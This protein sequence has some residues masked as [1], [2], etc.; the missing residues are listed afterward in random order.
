MN[1]KIIDS[2]LN[3]SIT[4]L[5]IIG[6][7]KNTG[8]TVTLNTVI[9][10]AM[11][12]D[13]RLALLSYGRDGEEVDAITRHKKPRVYIP[14]RTLFLTTSEAANKSEITTK[15][16]KELEY[17]TTMGRVGIYESGDYGG[18]CEL[19]GINS[20][21][22]IYQVKKQLENQIDLLLIDGALDR[23]SSAMPS[24]SEGFVLATGANIANT[25]ELVAKKTIIEIDKL[26]TPEIN[27]E[28]LQVKASQLLENGHTGVITKTGEVVK[29]AEGCS[30][31]EYDS[32][33][34]Y[35]YRNK[36][37]FH[38][39][40]I[41]GAIVDNL[42]EKLLYS[43]KLDHGNIIVKDGTKIFLK[44]RTKNLL[45]LRNISLQVYNSLELVAVTVNPWSSDG[46]YLNS[47]LIIDH[48]KEDLS[49]PVYDLLS[50]EY[51]NQT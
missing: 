28:A 47:Q 48:L 14:P 11:N 30:F 17:R 21:N 19:V 4:T 27:D 22:Q 9:S 3:K 42:V 44:E 8:K 36:E 25:E 46:T 18:N 12:K 34:S 13:L 39:L 10:E 20:A 5:A 16:V 29:L 40:V 24:L 31:S 41:N 43:V 23:K 32:I 2:I 1:N 50:S 7:E 33:C 15:L 49:V 6:M 45:Q 37:S 38:T 35:I 51:K 26:T